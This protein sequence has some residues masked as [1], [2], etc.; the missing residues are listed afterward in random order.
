MPM[1]E[2]QLSWLA[3]ITG[4]TSILMTESNAL[5]QEKGELEAEKNQEGISPEKKQEIEQKLI[6]NDLQKKLQDKRLK[7]INLRIK[8]AEEAKEREKLRQTHLMIVRSRVESIKQEI[9]DAF[10]VQ[11]KLK[12]AK[13][14]ESSG[15]FKRKLSVLGEQSQSFDFEADIQDVR[16]DFLKGNTPAWSAATAKIKT[17]EFQMRE[18]FY[19]WS[20]EEDSEQGYKTT[21]KE[22]FEEKDIE[23]ELYTPLV[24]QKVYP[25]TMVD[26][27]YSYVQQMIDGSN[28]A[29]TEEL[30]GVKKN[31][32]LKE[33]VVL[34]KSLVRNAASIAGDAGD[35]AEELGVMSEDVNETFEALTKLGEAALTTGA[36]VISSISDK[37]YRKAAAAILAGMSLSVGGLISNQT[38]NEEIG[39]CVTLAMKAAGETVRIDPKNPEEAINGF[40]E[41]AFG[42]LA[43][44]TDD[45]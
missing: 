5:D 22:L 41:V 16:S 28:D 31:A 24:R 43:L 11:V 4:N 15:L 13:F 17:Y 20:V 36:D 34:F 29:Y 26:A 38:G 14:I 27:E 2:K 42:G 39:T 1:N 21:K 7:A 32:V 8:N 25:D 40:I 19:D 37:E 44:K 3:E 9:L 33:N 35:I 18:L 10:N 45:V 30:S 12:R 6:L 23:K